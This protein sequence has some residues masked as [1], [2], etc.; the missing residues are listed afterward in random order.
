MPKVLSYTPAWLSRPSAGFDVFQPSANAKPPQYLGRQQQKYR[1]PQRTIAHR[2]REVFV[3]VGNE[4]RWADLE[5][6]RDAGEDGRSRYDPVRDAGEDDEKLYRVCQ[7]GTMTDTATD[8]KQVLKTPVSL[9]I[10]QLSVSPN[11]NYIAILTSHT[12]YVAVL[13]SSSH[14]HS[15][16]TS[17]LRLKSFQLGPTAH[18]LEQAPLVSALWH[19]LAHNGACL[20][21]VT[22]D[23]CVRLWELE[24]ENR[25]SFD[26]PALAID[27]KKLANATSSQ[28]DLRASKYGTNKGFSPDEVEMEVAAA[29][30]GGTGS[31]EEHG[32]SSMTLWIAM[33]EGDVYALCPL[34]PRKWC[35]PATLLPSLTTSVVAKAAML[36]NDP[37]T[38]ESE[39]RTSDQQTRW[40]ADIDGQDPLTLPIEGSDE[41][42]VME[43]YTRPAHPS[44]IPKLQGPFQLS[45]EPDFGEITDIHVIGPKLDSEALFGEDDDLDDENS[46]GLSISVICLAT[47]TNK[48]H[49]CLDIDGV[50]AEWLPSK[51]SRSYGLDDSDLGKEVLVFE[52]VDLTPSGDGSEC[53]P[54]LTASPVERYELFVTLP[55]GVYSLDMTPWIGNLEDELAGSSEEGASFRMGVLLDSAGTKVDQTMQVPLDAGSTTAAAIAIL[56]PSLGYFILTSSS[57]VPHAATLDIPEKTH[58]FA[59]DAAPSQLEGPEPRAPYQPAN[60]FFTPSALPALLDSINNSTASKLTRQ[61]IKQPLT[62]SPATLQLMT[63]AHRLLSS[64]THKLGLAAADLFRRCERMRAE[65]QE[66][67][68]KVN[69]IAG[70]IDNVTG[71]ADYADS[72]PDDEEGPNRALGKDRI[73]E[74]MQLSQ[75]RSHA[76]NE[77]VEALRRKMALLGGKQLSAKESAFAREVEKLQSAIMHTETPTSPHALLHMSNTSQQLERESGSL[78]HRFEEARRLQEALINQAE[79]ASK[80]R[81]GGGEGKRGAGVPEGFRRQKLAQVRGLLERETALVDAVSERLARLGGL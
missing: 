1:G 4:L 41:F 45:P 23:A 31:E 49:I 62:F 50:E 42:D 10:R 24:R 26:E 18:V 72:D 76:L 52:S 43:V 69:D 66:Q 35:A 7:L 15:Q 73:D 27:L 75:E 38:S 81:E 46:G 40:L 12:C 25:H 54:T 79:E 59:P 39:R 68:R 61:D 60:E 36:A 63:D 56:E 71:D 57:N 65:L 32:W 20:V 77:R 2:G 55:T 29:C 16:D 53:W 19:P 28:E 5:V 47:S 9:P 64:E 21:T 30:F 22:K 74:R 80:G 14:L 33:T 70:R 44:I 37:L 34:L 13:P 3:A 48:V 8:T 67:V 11:G 51:R 17:P 58:A 78:A 6:L